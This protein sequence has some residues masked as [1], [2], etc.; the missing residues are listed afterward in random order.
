MPV[1]R[2][3]GA[4]LS[5]RQGLLRDLSLRVSVAYMSSW[6]AERLPIFTSLFEM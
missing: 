1:Y 2:L 6:F 4:W 5:R 3:I